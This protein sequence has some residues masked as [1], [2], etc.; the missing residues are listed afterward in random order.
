MTR[1]FATLALIAAAGP[2]LAC[3]TV[4][5]GPLEVSRAWSRASIG[6]ARP[7]VVYLTIRNSGTADD[8]LMSITTPA[9]DMPMLHQTVMNDGVA[10]MPYAMQ[11]PFP[12]GEQVA[13]GKVSIRSC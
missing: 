5:A 3:E 9:A 2:A 12:A 8:A 10:S 1:I 7:G 13:L 6:T 4:T 11:V